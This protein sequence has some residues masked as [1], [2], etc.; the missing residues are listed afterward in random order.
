MIPRCVLLLA[1][2]AFCGV[3][4]VQPG[5]RTRYEMRMKWTVM[6]MTGAYWE[7]ASWGHSIR[8]SCPSGTLFSAPFQ[9]CVPTKAW[10]EFPYYPPPTTVNDNADQCTADQDMCVNPCLENEDIV[11]IGGQIING[12]CVCPANWVLKNGVCSFVSS[13][14]TCRSNEQWDMVQ[15]K[16][17]CIDGF[18]L[19]NGQCLSQPNA[20]GVCDGAPATA[21]LPGPMDCNAI[22]CA[23]Q[24]YLNETLY[25]TRNPKTFWQCANV[26]WIEE[27]PCAPGTCFDFNKQVCVHAID[28]VN[29]CN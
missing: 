19:I 1:V 8:K 6:G 14:D 18:Q 29:H 16:C 11:C 25:P 13:I 24:Q 17:V 12:Q 7:C 28:W 5:C 26:G 3:S 4:A 10:E 27:M 21:Y 23:E 15:Q 20:L 22:P 2:V 9:T